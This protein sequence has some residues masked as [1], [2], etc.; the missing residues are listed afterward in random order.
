[1]TT[2]KDIAR[3]LGVSVTLV[4][5][6]L[7]GKAGAIGIPDRT[8]R[9]ILETAAAMGYVPNATARMLRGAPTRTIGVVVYDFED[10]F[11]GV[12]IGE[13][14]RLAHAAEYSLVLVGF[15]HRQVDPAALSP[16][17]KHGVDGLIVVGSSE[18]VGWLA[19]LSTRRMPMARMGSGPA[20]AGLL[21]VSVDPEAGMDRLAEHL[22]RRG[23]KTAGFVGDD[24]PAHADR[25]R[26]FTASLRKHG[27]AT[28]PAWRYAMRAGPSG[29]EIAALNASR[30][31]ARPQ[32]LICASDMIAIATLRI[33]KEKGLA[34]P[35]AMAVTGF[36]DIPLAPLVCPSLT[37]LR[38]PV[39]SMA[40]AAF[41]WIS[42]E[43]PGPAQ[44][45]PVVFTPTL[46][47][48]ESA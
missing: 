15:E 18:D 33:L 45:L 20:V 12:L 1:M 5:R 35:G 39:A 26:G 36:D 44:P 21:S 13:L 40:R 19:T 46:V 10:P 31:G 7:A 27:L 47:I 25:Y 24:H 3:A 6:A 8:V 30:P 43:E 9:L 48:R 37:T 32:A 11:L 42:R 22:A 23:I 4:S 14:Q 2:Q 17:N 28:R 38:Q 41:E 34:V 16:L 29:R